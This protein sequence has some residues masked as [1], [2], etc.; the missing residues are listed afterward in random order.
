MKVLWF[1][2]TPP[3]A[4]NGGGKYNGGGWVDALS[5]SMPSSVNLAISYI[6]TDKKPESVSDGISWYPVYNKYDT[7]RGD[8]LMKMLGFSMMERHWVLS[9]MLRVIDEFKPD[10]IEV[11]GSERIY[12]LIA[13]H[14]GIPVVL[15]IQG[16][17]GECWKRFLPPGMSMLKFLSSG[18]TLSGMFA[19]M[20]YARSFKARCGQ[21]RK[22]L[23]SI[24]YFIGR[25]DWDKHCIGELPQCPVYFH[26]E[27]MLREP[28]YDNAGKWKGL[29]NENIT[30]MTTISEAPFKG[31]D[32]VLRTASVLKNEYGL[33]FRWLVYG[34]V[35]VPFYEAFTGVDAESVGVVPCGVADAMTLSS[36]LT[37]TSVYVHTSYIENSPNSLCEAQIVGVP[38]VVAEVGGIPSIVSEGETGLMVPSGDAAR[39]AEAICKL[40]SDKTLAESISANSVKAALVRHDRRKIVSGLVSIYGQLAGE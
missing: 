14:T 26:L 4:V 33:K 5:R 28:F 10:V 34:N 13:Q 24:R 35:D 20:Y 27:E 38:S 25:T 19:K 12:G 3:A 11:F 16:I 31:M 37:G 30:L 8:R 15:H 6:S 1:T 2:N 9:S 36:A 17:L 23:S 32:V 40:L 7:G 22:I 29:D 39:Y 18:H 21:E